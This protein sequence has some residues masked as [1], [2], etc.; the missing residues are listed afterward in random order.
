MMAP[1]KPQPLIGAWMSVI[2]TALVTVILQGGALLIWGAKIDSRISYVEAHEGIQDNRI[3]SLDING[4]RKLGIIADRQNIDESRISSTERKLEE[5]L[6]KFNQH[7]IDLQAQLK[8][9]QI[10]DKYTKP[11]KDK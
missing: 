5:L 6:V 9:Q 11:E 2:I 3:D 8:S 10:Q 1:A 7:L 4:T